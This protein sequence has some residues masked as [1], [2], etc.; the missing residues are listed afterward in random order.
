[1]ANKTF[2]SCNKICLGVS[3]HI[4]EY[5]FHR[6][7]D[8]NNL[9]RWTKFVF[10]IIIKVYLVLLKKKTQDVALVKIR[11]HHV[12][13]RTGEDTIS[14]CCSDIIA[15]PCARWVVMLPVCNKRFSTDSNKCVKT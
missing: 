15:T 9:L 7:S 10:V 12:G 4:L 5:I 1:M 13:C 6:T 2:L 14:S 3:P 11:Y 8:K